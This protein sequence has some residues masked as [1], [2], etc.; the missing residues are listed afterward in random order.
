[1]CVIFDCSWLVHGYWPLK[2]GRC[3]CSATASRVGRFLQTLMH[4][5]DT[6][7]YLGNLGK[8]DALSR[9]KK[10]YLQKIQRKELNVDSISSTTFSSVKCTR[11]LTSPPDGSLL[12]SSTHLC[13][14][15]NCL[16]VYLLTFFLNRFRYEDDRISWVDQFVMAYGG[17]RG[18]VCYGNKKYSFS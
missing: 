16:G 12:V 8:L 10:N 17:I 6:I 7:A 18:A 3:L 1:M 5:I 2:S 14:Y 15:S 11:W 9:K 13:R 4:A